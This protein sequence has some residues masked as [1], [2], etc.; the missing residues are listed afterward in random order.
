LSMGA[1]VYTCVAFDADND[2][3]AMDHL[4]SPEA[5][6]LDLDVSPR[7]GC[8]PLEVEFVCNNDL[9][10]M[11]WH[12]GDGTSGQGTTITHTYEEAGTYDVTFEYTAL[13]GCTYSSPLNLPITVLHRPDIAIVV[14]PPGP[15]LPGQTVS[16]QGV[17]TNTDHWSWSF[18]GIP[19]YVHVDTSRTPLTLPSAAGLYEVA[20]YGSV[21]Y[22]VNT[23]FTCF[24]TA[25]IRL[26]VPACNANTV[27]VPS[28]FSPNANGKND[29]QCVYGDCIE[30][31]LFRIF[32]RWGN[33]VYESNDPSACW[34]GLHNGEPLNPGVFTYHLVATLA[35]EEVVEKSG[36]ITL[37]R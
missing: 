28:A 19:P 11:T 6:I 18:G 24:D 12:F 8:E 37:V 17:G 30:R 13:T 3:L 32:D 2:C 1:G 36:N 33:K 35:T 15:Y 23:S 31:M 21:L 20:L 16:L 34:D 14:D 5:I 25:Y 29:G 9:A 22:N 27:F 7:K 10:A 4:V 26:E